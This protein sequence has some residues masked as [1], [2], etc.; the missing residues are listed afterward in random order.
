M[1]SKNENLALVRLMWMTQ[2]IPAGPALDSVDEAA[3]RD[4]FEAVEVCKSL[5]VH[6]PD[7]KASTPTSSAQQAPA[8]SVVTNDAPASRV[9]LARA[10]ASPRRVSR[11]HP[12]TYG[13]FAGLARAAGQGSAT[14][15]AQMKELIVDPRFD[16][17]D[18]SGA[19]PKDRKAPTSWPPLDDR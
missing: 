10:P 12:V 8:P 5:L 18:L 16:P 13:A 9:P 19:P 11:Q 6:V 4:L 2:Q 15:K 17:M 3:E 7:A 1:S 14:A